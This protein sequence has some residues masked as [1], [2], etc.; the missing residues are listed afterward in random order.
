M[1]LVTPNS[2]CVHE[3]KLKDADTAVTVCV[4]ETVNEITNAPQ[5]QGLTILN[6]KFLGNRRRYKFD[7]KATS[8]L[9]RDEVYQQFENIVSSCLGH[10]HL[11]VLFHLLDSVDEDVFSHYEESKICTDFFSDS[12]SSPISK[13]Q[14]DVFIGGVE[15]IFCEGIAEILTFSHDAEYIYQIELS[16]QS[17]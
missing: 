1:T 10:G 6:S 17:I 13:S 2:T 11:S 12:H 15:K 16:G 7:K 4:R 8:Y 3:R 5:F 9:A 14:R